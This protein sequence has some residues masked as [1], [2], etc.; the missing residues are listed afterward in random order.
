M[1]IVDDEGKTSEFGKLA[2]LDYI[3][4]GKIYYNSR[5][6]LTVKVISVEN[7]SVIYITT[8][9]SKSIKGLES[10]I[11][12]VISKI[13][14]IQKNNKIKFITKNIPDTIQGT[15]WVSLKG[16]YSFFEPMAGINIGYYLMDNVALGISAELNLIGY[17]LSR[18][19][20]EIYTK[21]NL[22]NMHIN[23]GIGYYTDKYNML[24]TIYYIISGIGYEI[25]YIDMELPIRIGSR[26]GNLM[27]DAG[28]NILLTINFRG[29]EK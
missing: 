12:K 18:Q 3:V 27:F 24:N 21:Y 10:T 7:A 25:N 13:Q 15:K 5:Y 8:G 4:V 19:N 14:I 29:M 2:S 9:S 11:K 17:P 23:F 16:T 26:M 1:G 28:I 6:Y 22:E 20:M